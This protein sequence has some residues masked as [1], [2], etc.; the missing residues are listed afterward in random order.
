M[1][2]AT[3]H[4]ELERLNAWSRGAGRHGRRAVFLITHRIS[5]ISQAHQILYREDGRI[6][7]QGSPEELMA[8]PDGRYRAF[9]ALQTTA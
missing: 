1:D 8:K 9:V 3:E 6:V 7:E 5:T 2:A 4:R